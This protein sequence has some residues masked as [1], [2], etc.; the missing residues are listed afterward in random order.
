MLTGSGTAANESILSS[1]VG[2]KN[3]LILS[4]GEFGE[5]LH[6]ISKIHNKNTFLLNFPWGQGLDLE[7]IK[8]HLARHKID[9][10]AMV[11]HETSSGILNSL[12]KV[13]AL[14]KDS[15]ALYVV[16]CVSSAGA[17]AIDVKRNNI[18]FFSSSS[19]KAIASYPG[20]SF[21]IGRASEF[22][23]IKELPVKTAYLNLYK[24]YTFLKTVYQTPNTPAIPLF[25]ALE[26]ALNNILE[27]G[28]ANR[29]A[30]LRAKADLLRKGMRA[31]G[32]KFLLDERDMCSMLTT[33]HVPAHIDV[34]FLRRKLREKSIIIY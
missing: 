34:A 22:E 1:V 4:N 28:T 3:I 11:H 10:V 20:L 17:E 16:D 18:A 14:V 8:D 9:V 24:F 32:L 26:Q 30:S 21:V 13:G 23:K 19:S 15:G 27:E 2:D 33:V 5:R 7:Q 12:E 31:L 6:A 29:Y 25:Y